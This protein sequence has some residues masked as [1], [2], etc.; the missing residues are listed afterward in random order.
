MGECS[1]V[2]PG[3]AH[4]PQFGD[5]NETLPALQFSLCRPGGVLLVLV[6]GFGF[7]NEDEW[8]TL[9]RNL[10][11][12]ERPCFCHGDRCITPAFLY[13]PFGWIDMH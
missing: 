10:A 9:R 12:I 3:P 8:D 6:V 2:V 7:E 4:L 5:Q 11:R 1:E 13:A